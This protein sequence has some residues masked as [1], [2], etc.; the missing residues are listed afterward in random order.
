ML[1]G[2]GSRGC[3]YG[4]ASLGVEGACHMPF[5][6]TSQCSGYPN[7]QHKSDAA[8]V[9]FGRDMHVLWCCV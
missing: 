1:N 7:I 9:A 5:M 4:V 3:I 2:R 6:T 8:E